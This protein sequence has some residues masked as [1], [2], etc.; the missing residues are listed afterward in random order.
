[1]E[2]KFFGVVP[3][4]SLAATKTGYS[5]QTLYNWKNRG[6]DAFQA[7]GKVDLS[8]L[9]EWLAENGLGQSAEHNFGEGVENT[10]LQYH[11]QNFAGG[12]DYGDDADS[13]TIQSL[14]VLH[15]LSD[16]DKTEAAEKYLTIHSK[17]RKAVADFV[18]WLVRKGLSEPME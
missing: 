12:R 17:I 14:R 15:L 9:G 16:D 11:R 7:D 1:M 2:V 18:E 8:R 10:M 6:C 3:T 5:R 4:I 13:V